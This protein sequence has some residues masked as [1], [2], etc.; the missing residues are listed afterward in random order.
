MLDDVNICLIFIYC[1]G[2]VS[3]FFFGEIHTDAVF[4]PYSPQTFSCATDPLSLF[5]WIPLLLSCL[6]F[7]P[8]SFC[9]MRVAYWSMGKGLFVGALIALLWL[10]YW[11]QYP[12]LPTPASQ[13]PWTSFITSEGAGRS[14]SPLSLTE[15]WWASFCHGLVL[16][17]TAVESPGVQCHVMP[18]RK[19][20][21][22]LQPLTSYI[23]SLI[24][25]EMFTE[26]WRGSRDILFRAWLW[27][28]SIFS[29]LGSLSLCS[30][31]RPL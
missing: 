24:S 19:C 30:H 23:F 21:R 3:F 11:R 29:T 6:F 7:F 28:V 9:L 26:P 4:Q 18:G 10:Y 17:R 20:S 1:F 22:T 12:H 5:N 15:G 27:A 13:Q 8:F 16:I 14:W 25:L 31:H 2:K